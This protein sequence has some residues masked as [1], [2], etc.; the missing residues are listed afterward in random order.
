MLRKP[1]TEFLLIILII[2]ISASIIIDCPKTCQCE[3]IYNSLE[4]LCVKKEKG[5]F[6][7]PLK[8]NDTNT[9]SF[10]IEK[11]KIVKHVFIQVSTDLF[12]NYTNLKEVN[13]SNNQIFNFSNG[14]FQYL[15]NTVDLDISHNS[16]KIISN[17]TFSY[18]EHLQNL[19][20]NNNNIEE[21]QPGLF[22]HLVNLKNLDIS[23][24]TIKII[25]NSTFSY[26]EHLQ[27]LILNNNNMKELQP[28]LFQNLVNLQTLDIS[29]NSMNIISN[30]TFKNLK[31]LEILNLRD[32][33]LEQLQLDSFQDLVSLQTLDISNN[34][35]KIPYKNLVQNNSTLKF[36]LI[37]HNRLAEKWPSDLPKIKYISLRNNELEF[38]YSRLENRLSLNGTIDTQYIQLSSLDN[39]TIQKYG[40]C[41][42]SS[43]LRFTNFFA[44]AFVIKN[45]QTNCEDCADIEALVVNTSNS[46][47]INFINVD[48][49]NCLSSESLN[50]FLISSECHLTNETKFK[51]CNANQGK[52][53]MYYL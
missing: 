39:R 37:P 5:E 16:M 50:A 45:S 3:L 24:N 9:T 40:D 32:N 34:S 10:N 6:K 41:D 12:Q 42:L 43:S 18:L 51:F 15:K 26:L 36:L 23:H 4:I 13:M 1:L 38:F 25:S 20:L 21:L 49:T 44:S 46:K 27:N 35:L 14:F 33:V 2:Q 52:V 48:D 28:G 47:K 19:I 30:N 8:F 17:N 31:Y 7:M 29:H 53:F 11:V 22:Q